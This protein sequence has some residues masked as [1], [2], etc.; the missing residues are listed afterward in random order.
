MVPKVL[1]VGVRLMDE[2]GTRIATIEAVSTG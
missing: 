1:P 2:L